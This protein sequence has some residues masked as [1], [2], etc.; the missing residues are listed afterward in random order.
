MD[1]TISN[2]SKLF[3][4]LIHVLNSHTSESGVVEALDDLKAAKFNYTQ[5]SI[6]HM[7]SCLVLALHD[8]TMIPLSAELRMELGATIHRHCTQMFQAGARLGDMAHDYEVSGGKPLTH[9]EILE[10]VDLRRGTAR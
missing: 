8:L 4:E 6:D 9:D 2:N 3:D 7:L 1:Y 10:E 5:R